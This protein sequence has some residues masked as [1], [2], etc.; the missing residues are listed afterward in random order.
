V[1]ASLTTQDKRAVCRASRYPFIAISPCRRMTQN[2]AEYS[3]L[4]RLLFCSC[5]EWVSRPVT[6]QYTRQGLLEVYRALQSTTRLLDLPPGFPHDPDVTL[7]TPGTPLALLP[8]SA[9]EEDVILQTPDLANI[10]RPENMP[11]SLP[12]T[13]PGVEGKQPVTSVAKAPI[14][15][16]TG[17][18]VEKMVDS[19]RHVAPQAQPEIPKPQGPPVRT[20]LKPRAPY[21]PFARAAPQAP[22][23]PTVQSSPEAEPVLPHGPQDLLRLL[24][25]GVS[26]KPLKPQTS[27]AG[28]GAQR[29]L[30]PESSELPSILSMLLPAEDR[31]TPRSVPRK[32][33][34]FTPPMRPVYSLEGDTSSPVREGA[35]SSHVAA[36]DWAGTTTIGPSSWGEPGAMPDHIKAAF[37]RHRE[38]TK[39]E[40]TS[41]AARKAAMDNLR[42]DVACC[43]CFENP[44][45]AA[46]V[47]CGHRLCFDCSNLIHDRRG[48]CPLCNKRIESVLKLFN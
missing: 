14:P 44:K 45:N 15:R 20:A 24:T 29:P 41:P 9:E 1:A 36:S 8:M 39:K 23:T 22:A 6:C 47:P 26:T 40:K 19:E 17:D 31:K 46:L 16:P 7:E 32:P 10:R 48:D 13:K 28:P 25:S 11:G 38:Q 42:E 5:V 12:S 37:Q 21:N 35:E 33:K 18:T 34:P 43:I 4:S 2:H 30:E 27:E 3:A